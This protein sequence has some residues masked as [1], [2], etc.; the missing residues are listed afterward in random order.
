MPLTVYAEYPGPGPHPM[1]TLGRLIARLGLDA[2]PIGC[3]HDGYHDVNGY[4][5]P[6]L[7]E[8]TDARV[9]TARDLVDAM[10]MVKSEAEI[11][12][13]RR[14]AAWG[15]PPSSSSERASV[16]AS[17]RAR[18]GSRRRSRRCGG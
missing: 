18:S 2:E 12:Q 8:V 5:G 10:R 15:T 17:R 13:L 3:D 7:S 16:P 4:E 14:S 1:E 9:V 6:A 11:D